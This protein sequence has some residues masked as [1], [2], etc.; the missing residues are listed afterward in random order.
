MPG[1]R[2]IL[3]TRLPEYGIIIGLGKC[4]FGPSEFSFLGHHIC[5]EGISPMPTAVDAVENFMKP[6]KQRVLCRYL[7]MVN[8]YYRFIPHCVAELTPLNTLLTAANEGQIRLSWTE[9]ANSA[10]VASKQML[11]N[12]ILLVHPN[13]LAPLNVTCDAS[14]FA[15]GGVLQECVDNIWQPLSYFSK[16]LSTARHSAFDRDLLAVYATVRH[17]RH[18]IEG[19]DFFFNTV[20]KP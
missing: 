8:Y 19:Y 15:I 6:E 18:N 12:T 7:G 20:H 14:D 9:S 13:T 5:S 1:T 16:K 11:A 17:G 2:I 3:F 10:F 4:Q